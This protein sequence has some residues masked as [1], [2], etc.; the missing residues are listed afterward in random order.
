[1][2]PQRFSPMPGMRAQRAWTARTQ[3]VF[4]DGRSV[5]SSLRVLQPLARA[6]WVA[7]PRLS[8]FGLRSQPLAMTLAG[9]LK[10]LASRRAPRTPSE[11]IRMRTP[12]AYLVSAKQC[13]LC[14][15]QG[16]N[17][18]HKN[19]PWILMV[20]MGWLIGELPHWWDMATMRLWECRR[21]AS[22]R[23]ARN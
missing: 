3:R 5:L 6:T 16:C 20:L 22:A 12:P 19:D 21:D 9:A 15:V 8:I 14:R 18:M 11:T 13:K 2:P 4:V 1:M 7:P 10:H 17:T 23:D